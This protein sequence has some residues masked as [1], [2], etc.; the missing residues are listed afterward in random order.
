MAA[1]RG[2]LL[3]AHLTFDKFTRIIGLHVVPP[4]VLTEV[5]NKFGFSGDRCF[6]NRFV[7]SAYKSLFIDNGIVISVS[8]CVYSPP[9]LLPRIRRGFGLRRNVARLLCVS[10][11]L[12]TNK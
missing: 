8:R 3:L 10:I 7:S 1:G 2:H 9:F 4:S 12:R 5:G 6:S 11:L